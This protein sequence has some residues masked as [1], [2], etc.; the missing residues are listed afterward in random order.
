MP[1][2]HLSAN[3][4]EA[5]QPIITFAPNVY[6]SAVNNQ[7]N[8]TVQPTPITVKND[9]RVQPTPIN[10]NVTVQPAEVILPEAQTEAEII[11]DKLTGKKTIRVK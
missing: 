10:N 11:T 9:V 2:I 6:P 8:V 1:P 4:P 3:M 5:K 7:N